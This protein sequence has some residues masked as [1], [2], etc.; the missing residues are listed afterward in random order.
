MTENTA[1]LFKILPYR[2]QFR[3]LP[4]LCV[5]L[6]TFLAYVPLPFNL[7]QLPSS[8]STQR[9]RPNLVFKPSIILPPT[10]YLLFLHPPHSSCFWLFS[11]TS[12]FLV[13]P[14]IRSGFLNGILKAFKPVSLNYSTLFRLILWILSLFRNATLTRFSFSGF[15][16]FLFCSLIALTPVL[17]EN[18]C[19]PPSWFMP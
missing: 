11:Y 4:T 8:L 6:C 14:L 9:Y 13:S 2:T 1:L 16:D 10:L 7:V 15:L 19:K 17:G 5:P 3:Y 18:W 12:W